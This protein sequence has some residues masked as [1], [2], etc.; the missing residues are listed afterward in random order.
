MGRRQ[1][2]P[3]ARV[4][5]GDQDVMLVVDELGEDVGIPASGRCVMFGTG[6]QRNDSSKIRYRRARTEGTRM[7]QVRFVEWRRGLPVCSVSPTTMVAVSSTIVTHK[8]VPVSDKVP[9]L[10]VPSFLTPVTPMAL[11]RF[12]VGMI[13]PNDKENDTERRRNDGDQDEDESQQQQSDRSDWWN[14]GV[15]QGCRSTTDAGDSC[16]DILPQ[17]GQLRSPWAST[18]VW[19]LTLDAAFSTEDAQAPGCHRRGLGGFP[20][21]AIP[22]VLHLAGVARHVQRAHAAM[23]HDIIDEEVTPPSAD[24]ERFNFFEDCPKVER[25]TLVV[26]GGAEL[27]IAEAETMDAIAN[28]LGVSGPRFSLLLKDTHDKDQVRFT[29]VD[30]DRPSTRISELFERFLHIQAHL[31][32]LAELKSSNVVNKLPLLDQI[33][34][35]WLNALA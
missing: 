30:A 20:D 9:R 6:G 1:V 32:N 28:Q 26:R 21:V 15:L 22:L 27:F 2:E 23:T 10:E 29:V 17:A 35:V 19:R 24:H 8:S 18:N 11:C 34:K 33:Q 7:P 16:C 3:S 4:V 12:S 25:R 31:D 5:L 13:N 14:P